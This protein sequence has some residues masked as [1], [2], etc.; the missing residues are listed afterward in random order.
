MTISNKAIE[1]LEKS[2]LAYVILSVDS[3][4]LISIFFT[5]WI[6]RLGYSPEV[7]RGCYKGK[8]ETVFMV[9]RTHLLTYLAMHPVGVFLPFEDQ[10]SILL[11][12]ECN[13]AYA[14]LLYLEDGRVEGLGSMVQVTS[15]E[16]ATAEA[17]T[18]R[19]GLYWIAKRENPDKVQPPNGWISDERRKDLTSVVASLRSDHFAGSSRQQACYI[20]A[21]LIEND[22]LGKETN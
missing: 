18:Q 22:Y 12:S 13:K 20:A 5:Q 14:Q 19:N 9:R 15:A 2:N 4:A 3:T 10:E 11:V 6:S 17:W 1:Q 7:G 16:A 8:V 21:D